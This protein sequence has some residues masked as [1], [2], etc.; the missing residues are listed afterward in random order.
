METNTSADVRK[1]FR[2]TA[3]IGLA[4]IASLAVYAVLVELI[5]RQNAPFGGFTPMPDVI[6]TLRYALLGAAVLEFPF[7]QILNKAML[8]PKATFFRNVSTA[9]PFSPDVQRLISS[10]IIT[11]ALCES[12]AIFGLVLFLVQ[13]KTADF[14]LFLLISLFYFSIFF[15]RYGAWEA[16]MRERG[17][18]VRRK[19]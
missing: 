18:A 8:S 9:G 13:G 2:I 1:A 11:F 17:K 16:W 6:D 15:P 3:I 10:A 19:R 7:I 5:T 12:V 14:Y 4:M